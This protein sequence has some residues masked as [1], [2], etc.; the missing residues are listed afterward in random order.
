MIPR[1]P[2]TAPTSAAPARPPSRAVAIAVVGAGFF[3]SGLAWPGL[4]GRLPI[5]LMLKNQL[6]LPPEDVATFWAV[7]TL[8]WYL[9]PLAGLIADA[10]PLLGTRRRG[11]LLAGAATAAILWMVM[12]LAPRAY[13][14]LLAAATAINVPLVFCSTALGGVLVELG[15]RYD[16]TGRL[17]SVRFVAVGAMSLVAGPLGGWLASR[18]FGWTAAAGALVLLAFTALA[19]RL[20]PEPR[21][22]RA[23]EGAA[24]VLAAARGHLDA[25][26][27]SRAMWAAGGLIFLVYLAPG[28]QTPLLY[29]QQD[30]LG[31][32]PSY[33]GTLQLI[34]GAAAIAGALGYGLVCR[35]V[36]LRTSLIGGIA[37]N[38]A[39]TLLYLGYDS[40]R[41]AAIITALGAL[42]G[43]MATLPLFDLAARAAPRGAEGLG[44]AL[45]LGIESLAMFA[46]SE[47]LGAALYGGLHAGWRPL[48]WINA[49]STAAVLLFVPFLP[50]SLLTKPEQAPGSPPA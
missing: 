21:Q 6:G 35:R 44:Y 23:R 16:A 33:M 10:Y 30:T 20:Y 43:T 2:E 25:I 34:G 14:P 19:A 50:R 22:A 28:F 26:A 41:A 3:A 27:R 11:Y 40:R 24:T 31:F 45:L 8:P 47:K 42:F 12:A 7:A 49:A 4:M 32:D 46:V 37:V 18:P 38:A 5:G 15:Q 36:S 13:R 1:P 29:H 17:S 48:V 39:V 9:K